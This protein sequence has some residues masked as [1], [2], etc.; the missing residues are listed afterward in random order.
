MSGGCFDYAFRHTLQF[1]DELR[2]QLDRQKEKASWQDGYRPK[3]SDEIMNQLEN[4][5]DLADYVG[6]LMKETEWLYSDDISE[7][8]FMDRICKL[9]E[10]REAHDALKLDR[11]K[12]STPRPDP[13]PSTK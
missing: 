1:A 10:E 6:A 5:A 13:A 7:D 12:P 4:I 2:N 9:M 11:E 8:T 3:Y